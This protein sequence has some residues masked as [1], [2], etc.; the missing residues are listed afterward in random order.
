MLEGDFRRRRKTIRGGREAWDIKAEEGFTLIVL[1]VEVSQYTY[2]RDTKNGPVERCRVTHE[3]A[4]VQT[5]WW[6]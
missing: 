2:I 1:T 4:Y 5:R 3:I 6:Y